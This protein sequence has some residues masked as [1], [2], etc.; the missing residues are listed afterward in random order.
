VLVLRK[1]KGPRV[2]DH[3]CNDV[4]RD[5]PFVH[6]F[7]KVLERHHANLLLLGCCGVDCGAVHRAHIVALLHPLGWVVRFPKALQ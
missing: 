4:R 3:L 2:K 5:A 7:L 6:L 1:I